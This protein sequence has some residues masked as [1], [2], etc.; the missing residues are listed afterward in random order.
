MKQLRKNFPLI[1][2]IADNRRSWKTK[3]DTV[4]L[5]DILKPLPCSKNKKLCT[6]NIITENQIRQ[7]RKAVNQAESESKVYL[8]AFPEPKTKRKHFE[9]V[10]DDPTKQIETN[11]NL[12]VEVDIGVKWKGNGAVKEEP[13]SVN[14]LPKRHFESEYDPPFRQ[15]EAK[16]NAVVEADNDRRND[17]PKWRGISF[18][19]AREE[20]H[21]QNLKKNKINQSSTNQEG[22]C[23]SAPA[24]K[25]LGTRKGGVFGKFQPPTRPKEPHV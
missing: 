6:N 7:L 13:H 19:T 1:I 25:T 2:N 23:I 24:K 20:L 21:L 14:I 12:D 22:T 18:R 5:E 11:F 15:S 16:L 10:Y 8:E 4:K 17:D 3:L 9:P